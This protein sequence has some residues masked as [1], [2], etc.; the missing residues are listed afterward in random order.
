ME[1]HCYILSRCSWSYVPIL[2]QT[3]SIAAILCQ[4]QSADLFIVSMYVVYLLLGFHAE[5]DMIN[6]RTEGVML[7]HKSFI[8]GPTRSSLD[9]I[10]FFSGS[11][12]FVETFLC[13]WHFPSVASVTHMSLSIKCLWPFVKVSVSSLSFHSSD[14]YTSL[15]K[16]EHIPT[17][18]PWRFTSFSTPSQADEEH[19]FFLCQEL[20]SPHHPSLLYFLL[21]WYS[22]HDMYL[23]SSSLI[24]QKQPRGAT[25]SSAH[26]R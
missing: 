16:W 19:L 9:F 5:L 11:S 6:R 21:H 2:P 1:K 24:K 12:G 8:I 22:Q 18:S 3:S 15:K 20:F 25:E 14:N 26:M 13:Q 17:N 7:H 10:F 4:I 23:L